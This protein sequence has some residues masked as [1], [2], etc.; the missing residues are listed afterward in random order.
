MSD[1]HLKLIRDNNIRKIFNWQSILTDRWLEKIK[2]L[3][4]SIYFFKYFL[5]L[6]IMAFFN[7]LSI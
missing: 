3:I 6:I 5:K 2:E 1:T 4:F 7:T